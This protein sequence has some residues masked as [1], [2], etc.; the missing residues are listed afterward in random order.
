MQ[1]ERR[2]ELIMLN[3]FGVRVR[4]GC[5]WLSLMAIC[6][7][8][9]SGCGSVKA[10]PAP[11]VADQAAFSY[12]IGPGDALNIV[13]WRNPELSSKISVRPDGR[14]T[15]PLVED[16]DAQGKTPTELARE[17]EGKL[18]KYLQEPVVTIVVDSFGGPY[19]EQ[20]RVVGA[21]AKP[22]AIPY[23][24]K[25][26]VLDVM[27]AV[28]GLTDFAAGNEATIIRSRERNRVY[29]VRLNDLL[30]RGDISANVE[31]M[32]GDVLIIPEG[33]F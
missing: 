26:S 21:A 16:L 14:I 24:Q 5:V 12:R 2:K 19:T 10:P 23:R 30:K 3:I 15:V 17:I 1:S 4:A 33:W 29:S 32:P 7:A 6:V 20:V 27:I 18:A 25:M 8:V 22:A 31:M 13:V 9:V 28:G 11:R